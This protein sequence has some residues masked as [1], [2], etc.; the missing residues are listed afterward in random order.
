LSGVSF[1][2]REFATDLEQLALKAVMLAEDDVPALGAFLNDLD[3]LGDKLA[4]AP[5]AA[6]LVRQMSE[7][8]NRLVLSEI[9]AAAQAVEYL[10]LGVSLLQQWVQ[11]GS[12]PESGEEWLTYCRILDELGLAGPESPGAS[13]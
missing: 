11:H 13:A 9:K 10:G 4:P 8:A 6:A 2:P 1:D 5:D 12:W 7:V 3:A